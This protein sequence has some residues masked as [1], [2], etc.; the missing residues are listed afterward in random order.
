M[1][2]ILEIVWHQFYFQV[3]G[4]L[5]VLRSNKKIKKI[6]ETKLSSGKMEKRKEYVYSQKRPKNYEKSS[7]N[8]HP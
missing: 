6:R 7:G 4:S 5:D 1:T 2:G 3:F 8:K